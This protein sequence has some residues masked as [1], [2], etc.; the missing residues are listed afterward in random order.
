ATTGLGDNNGSVAKV[1]NLFE[2]DQALSWVKGRH[3]WKFGFN[4]LSTRFAFFTPPKP[5]GSFTFNGAYTGYGLADFLYGHPIS[6]QIDITKYFSLMRYKP[7]FYLQDNWRVTKKLTLNYGLRDEMVT[8]W[9]ER[10]NRL[11]GFD[12]RNGG[13]LVA[14]G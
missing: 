11:A 7:I 1:N 14:V 8:P 12:P 9:R 6:S 2:I 4:F 13:T 3:E 5:N 10:H